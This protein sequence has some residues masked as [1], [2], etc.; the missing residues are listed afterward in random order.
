MT[1]K[2]LRK[3][4]RLELLEML[5]DVSKENENLKQIVA[6]NEEENKVTKS[7]ESLSDV[8]TRLNSA[9]E[10][11]NR[12]SDNIQNCTTSPSVL[13]APQKYMTS[14]A[15]QKDRHPD[16][17]LYCLIMTHFAKNEKAMSLLPESLQEKIKNRIK[18]ILTVK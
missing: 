2:E 7:I 12:F 8:T 5:L 6:K 3:L 15:A 9:I 16:G 13:N 4:S 1:D 11:I 14:G 18:E 10:Q 17:E